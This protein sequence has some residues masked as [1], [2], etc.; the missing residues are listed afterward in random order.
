MIHEQVPPKNGQKNK[1]ASAAALSER[2][3]PEKVTAE[4]VPSAR[5]SYLR[6]YRTCENK[7]KIVQQC[8]VT[9]ATQR[10]PSI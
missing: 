1:A 6:N 4:Q 9:A 10:L 8:G 3:P 5:I 2:P 7:M